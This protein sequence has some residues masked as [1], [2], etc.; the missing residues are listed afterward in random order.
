[1]DSPDAREHGV[2]M[3]FWL[4]LDNSAEQGWYDYWNDSAPPI[5]ADP[6]HWMPLPAPPDGT[7]S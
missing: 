2:M 4:A 6:T 3:G 5:D 1:M 7:V